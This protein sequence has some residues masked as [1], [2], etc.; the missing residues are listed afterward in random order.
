PL[1]MKLVIII[2]FMPFVSAS[3]TTQLFPDILF[4]DFSAFVELTFGFKISLATVLLLL[5]T[6]TENP[7][8]LNLHAHQQNPIEGENKTGF[9]LDSTLV[10]CCYALV[11]NDI[12]TVFCHGEY[13]SKQIHQ[14]TKLSTKLDAFAK[15]LNLTPYDHWG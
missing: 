5:F 12:K 8:L 1:F 10:L 7:E 11:K 6:M 4:R 2:A 3:P 9:W 15:L 13:N 14:V